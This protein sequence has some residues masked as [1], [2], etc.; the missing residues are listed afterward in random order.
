MEQYVTSFEELI[1]GR[2][3]KLN[4]KNSNHAYDLVNTYASS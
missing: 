2:V 3:I 4:I 1:P